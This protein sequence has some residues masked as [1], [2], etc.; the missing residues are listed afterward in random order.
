MSDSDRTRGTLSPADRRYLRGNAEYDSASSERKTRSRIRKR[1]RQSIADFTLLFEHLERRDRLAVLDEFWNRTD[2][3]VAL[4]DDERT[5]GPPEAAWDVIDPDGTPHLLGTGGM[6]A[7]QSFTYL[8]LYDFV[9]E[10]LEG[11]PTD[12]EDV[13]AELVA[14]ALKDMFGHK[15]VVVEAD[16]DVTFQEFDADVA[17]LRERFETDP[18]AVT[19]QE[20]EWLAHLREITVEEMGEYVRNSADE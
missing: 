17:K 8:L 15:G 7:M 13:V 3:R 12:F 4:Q 6:K 16:V 18:E 9:V 10:E 14:E 19:D 11:T 1:T 2:A 20:V 5:E